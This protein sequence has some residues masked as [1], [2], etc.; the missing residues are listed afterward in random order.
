MRVLVF[1]PLICFLVACMACSTLDTRLPIDLNT[2]IRQAEPPGTVFYSIEAAAQAAMTYAH[3]RHFPAGRPQILAGTIA[4][5]PGGFSYT[6]PVGSSQD[7]PNAIPS[8]RHRLEPTD[9]ASY[10]V[11][12]WLGFGIAARAMESPRAVAQRLVD[13]VDPE[14]RPVFLLTPSLEIETYDGNAFRF[15]G[16]LDDYSQTV[17]ADNN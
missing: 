16:S 8:L 5:V 10:L 7:T 14:R 9:A 12:N 17:T 11:Y 6:S 4:R 1:P 13:E 2:E 3:S 15:F